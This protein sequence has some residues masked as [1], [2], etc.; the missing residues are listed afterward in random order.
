[1]YFPPSQIQTDLYTKGGELINSVTEEPY[2]GYY[3]LTADGSKFTGR[4]PDDK[5]TNPLIRK[6]P[7]ANEDAEGLATGALNPIA[8]NYSLPPIYVKKN[9]LGIGKQSKP[10]QNPTQIL[11]IPSE[12]DYKIGEY[13]RFFCKKYSSFLYIEISLEEFK[14]FKN[15]DLNVNW[16]KYRTFQIPWIITGIRSKV[17]EINKKTIARTER[18]L[19]IRGFSNYFKNKFDQFFRYNPGENL[20]TDGTEFLNETTGRRYRGLYH[21]HPDKG[22]MVGA[23]HVPSKHD[24]LIPISGSTNQVTKSKVVSRTNS[25]RSRGYSGGY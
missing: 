14:K 1:M 9:S 18:N 4:N 7:D 21:I 3:F 11:S 2:K 10:P 24:Y 12:N 13:Q 8:S 22:P 23:Q 15:R 20:K 25:K 17:V 19:K 5:P 16:R 6:I